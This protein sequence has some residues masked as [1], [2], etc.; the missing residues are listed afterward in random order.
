VSEFLMQ[1]ELVGIRPVT[2]E[3][4]RVCYDTW[5]DPDVQRNLD[6]VDNDSF[7]VWLDKESRLDHRC[8]LGCIIVSL[9]DG[10]PAGYVSLG[11]FG[12]EPQLVILLLLPEYR[13]RG[14]GGEASRLIIDY[15]F[16]TMGL[17]RI[18][19]GTNDS[20]TACQQML[21]KLGFARD[22][23]ADESWDSVYGRGKV[24]ELCYLLD[25]ET[26][27][28]RNRH[29][30]ARPVVFDARPALETIKKLDM[31]RLCGSEGEARAMDVI[32]QG[33]SAVGVK[34]RYHTFEDWWVEPVDPHLELRGRKLPVRPVME[35]AFL[36]GFDFMS[37]DALTVDVSAGLASADDCDGRIAFAERCDP[38]S[39]VARDAR[40]QLMALEFDP[41]LE[42]YLWGQQWDIERVPAAYLRVEDIA[43]VRDS[44]G[45]CAALRWGLRRVQRQY[46][47]LV[48]EIPGTAKPEECV[49]LGAH[50]DSFP[51][52]VGSSD[53]ATGCAVL[54]EAAKWFAAHPPARTVR[55]AWFTGEEIDR[56]GSNA[57]ARD[58]AK[59]LGG[60]KLMVNVDTGYE[61]FTGPAW[62]YVTDDKWAT[63][64][65]NLTGICV[66][67]WP[68]SEHSDTGPFMK[69]GIPVFF[70]C[71]KSKQPAHLPTDRPE[72]IDPHKLQLLGSLNIEAAILAASDP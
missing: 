40:A 59:E 35:Q 58:F 6:F 34:W 5:H 47:N 33:L 1:G 50:I 32:A 14:L 53:D 39:P 15:G 3:D 23:K 38:G 71:G 48:A 67:V 12:K 57:Y 60:A 28:T 2:P 36:S 24:T 16:A 27:R 64:H 37:S 26:W 21:G 4:A 9:A 62:L 68:G 22:P 11:S 30:K 65:F 70:A 8:W 51:G 20:N 69:L 42:S 7:E 44:L 72:T 43:L 17:A 45:E 52:T 46:R 56:R 41:E 66:H 61:V 63:E 13:G 10:N 19:A 31:I 29:D 54:L 25:R 49:I 18:E 55:L